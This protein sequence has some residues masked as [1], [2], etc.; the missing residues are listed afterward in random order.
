MN[1]SNSKAR[2]RFSWPKLRKAIKFYE[3]ERLCYLPIELRLDYFGERK[4]LN[5]ISSHAGLIR[6]QHNDE[7]CSNSNLDSP[8]LA[9]M[10]VDVIV[11]DLSK[12]VDGQG[13]RI[14]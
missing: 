9:T 10:N 12:A 5:Y 8:V 13:G 11:L 7:L 4:R 6:G 14:A 3:R 2:P 1:T